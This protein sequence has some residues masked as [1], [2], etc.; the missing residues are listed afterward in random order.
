MSAWIRT[1]WDAALFRTDA[2]TGFRDRR[3]AFFRGFLIIVIVALI[4]GLPVLVTGLVKAFRPAAELTEVDNAMKGFE[5]GLAQV[6]PF[7]GGIPAGSLDQILEQIRQ[8]MQMG[9]DIA[10]QIMALPTILPK[11]LGGIFEATGAWLSRP[12]TTA[13][14]PM[15]QAVLAT[16]LGYGIWVMLFAKLLGGRATL[17]RFFGTTAL[18]AGPHVLNILAPLP[19]VGF[20]AGFV[21]FVWGVAVYV[22]ATAV[23]HELSGERAVLA[24]ALPLVV[25]VIVAFLLA[26]G[27]ASFIIIATNR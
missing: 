26:M 25:A 8:G 20:L 13:G 16:W 19:V 4:A 1:V 15:S 22:K 23:S 14:F 11:P 17:A 24:V 18:F 6:A 3:D 5:Q 12:F 2:F 7:L 9:V 21:A 27:L 10:T